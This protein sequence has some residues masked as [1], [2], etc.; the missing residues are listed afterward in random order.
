M[1]KDTF[2]L[3]R[4]GEYKGY[5]IHRGYCTTHGIGSTFWCCGTC[6]YRTFAGRGGVKSHIT[7]FHKGHQTR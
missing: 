7:K 6:G 3:R 1:T 2:R 4:V 5:A